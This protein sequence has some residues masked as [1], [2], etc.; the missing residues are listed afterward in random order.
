MDETHKDVRKYLNADRIMY[1]KRKAKKLI[2][3]DSFELI[4]SKN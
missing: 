2:W 4:N 3:G 1:N